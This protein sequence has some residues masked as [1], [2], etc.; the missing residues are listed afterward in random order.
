MG[1]YSAVES[2]SAPIKHNRVRAGSRVRSY[3]VLR[4]GPSKTEPQGQHRP[5]R[6]FHSNRIRNNLQGTA[7]DGAVIPVVITFQATIRGGLVIVANVGVSNTRGSVS[8]I[9]TLR[10]AGKVFPP[11]I[12]IKTGS[13]RSRSWSLMLILMRSPLAIM[14]SGFSAAVFGS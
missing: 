13:L 6:W 2:A 9:T 3:V 5:N 10:S 12:A 11:V 4:R 8:G 1:L 7:V 14:P